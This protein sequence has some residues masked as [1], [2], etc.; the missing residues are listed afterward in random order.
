MGAAVLGAEFSTA[1]LLSTFAGALG[2]M[3][4]IGVTSPKLMS[5]IFVAYGKKAS[6][7][8][9]NKAKGL[10]KV[11]DILYSVGKQEGFTEKVMS[12]MTWGQLTR[13]LAAPGMMEETPS[14]AF[15]LEGGIGARIMGR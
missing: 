5:R 9:I 10:N 2:A 3:A 11:M 8:A 13:Y 6:K 12:A 15:G 4:H 7:A 14:G 1:A